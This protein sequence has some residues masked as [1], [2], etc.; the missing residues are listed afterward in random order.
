MKMIIIINQINKE[1]VVIYIHIKIAKSK[2]KAKLV[3]I[4]MMIKKILKN[5]NQIL[6]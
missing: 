3:Q 4:K 6:V 5:N 2:I 1:K